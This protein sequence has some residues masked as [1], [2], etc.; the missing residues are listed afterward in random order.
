MRVMVLIISDLKWL[1][2]FHCFFLI[3]IH[4]KM[5]TMW[6]SIITP[7]FI[8]APL[9]IY[10]HFY[11]MLKCQSFSICFDLISNDLFGWNF[12]WLCAQWV[13]Y[14][15]AKLRNWN[16]CL[17]KQ[18]QQNPNEF[19]LSTGIRYEYWSKRDVSF[20]KRFARPDRSFLF[21]SC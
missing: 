12:S 13:N 19:Q 15:S 21:C 8:I 17:W 14:Y 5:T 4:I 7:H 20:I 10:H 2:C 3:K 6:P 16:L 1:C 18:Q 11:A 9:F